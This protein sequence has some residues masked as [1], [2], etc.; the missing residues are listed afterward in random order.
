MVLPFAVGTIV[1]GDAGHYY[2]ARIFFFSPSIPASAFFGLLFLTAWIFGPHAA[3]QIA[4]DF[5]G[6]PRKL[7]TTPKIP[8]RFS[9]VTKMLQSRGGEICFFM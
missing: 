3:P 4:Q 5:G 1:M 7:R 8:H 9:R 2:P 6:R